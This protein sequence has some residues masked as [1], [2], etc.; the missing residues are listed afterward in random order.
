MWGAP[1]AWVLF[2]R[3]ITIM[4]SGMKGFETNLFSLESASRGGTDYVT[5]LFSSLFFNLRISLCITSPF[6]GVSKKCWS[7]TASDPQALAGCALGA[8]ASTLGGRTVCCLACT[9]PVVL[10]LPGALTRN[11]ILCV[12]G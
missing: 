9:A 7:V 10:S 1:D 4:L 6:S 5:E 8:G 3:Y 2:L 11:P 12:D